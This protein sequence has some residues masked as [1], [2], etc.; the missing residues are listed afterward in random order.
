MTRFSEVVA[1][2]GKNFE[3]TFILNLANTARRRQ[4]TTAKLFREHFS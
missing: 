1:K 3:Q 2:K 4:M